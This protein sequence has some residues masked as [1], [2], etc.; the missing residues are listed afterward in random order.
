MKIKSQSSR[1]ETSLRS[2]GS[3]LGRAR[4]SQA[5]LLTALLLMGSGT[6]RAQRSQPAAGPILNHLNGV[7]TWYRHLENADEAAGR[8]SDALY[9]EDARALARRAVE[10]AF[11]S[12]ESEVALLPAQEAKGPSGSSA[13]VS[14]QQQSLAKSAASTADRIRLLQ[15][16]IEALNTRIP[17]ARGKRRKDLVSQRDELGSE[18]DLEKTLQNAIQKISAFLSNGPTAQ[19]GIVKQIADLKRTIPD[20][21]ANPQGRSQAAK[22]AISP[23][24][25]ASG[26]GL[27]GRAS[28]LFSQLRAMETV[29]ALVDEATAVRKSANDIRAPLLAMLRSILL[30]G[31]QLANQP[32]TT[33][34]AQ[35]E[36]ARESLNSLTA[37]FKQLSNA[38]V[39]LSQEMIVLDQSR[40]NLTQW[41]SSISAEDS[42]ILRSVLARVFAILIGLGLVIVFSEVWRR[43]TIRYVRETRR[44]RQLLLVRRFVTAFLMVVVIALGFVTE[45]SSLATFAG[46]LT[47]GIAVALQTVILSI[48]AYFFLIGRYGVRVGDRITVSGVTGEVVDIGL[49]RFHMMELAG[50]EIDLYP[51]GRMVAFSNSVLF[52]N[53]PLFRQLPGTAYAWHEVAVSFQR[54]GNYKDA[55][56]K[57]LEGVNSVYSEYREKLERQYNSIERLTDTSI[58]PPAPGTQVRFMENGFELV[59][60]YP[61]DVHHSSEIDTQVTKRLTEIINGVP[62][63]KAAAGPVQVRPALKA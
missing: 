48:A 37:R 22:P 9:L 38:S 13:E 63:F 62:E 54:D 42:Q 16:Q 44:R 61:V 6:A 18:L 52:Q 10:L 11:Q 45:F 40:A 19:N 28:L 30:E 4:L 34:P 14:S 57:L 35:M 59:V 5:T 47:A 50:T 43:A 24:Q 23:S 2:V 56:S 12:A 60:R 3:G 32:N 33:D 7:I 46:F 27:I 53:T 21:S 8:P 15:S 20:L 29:E 17:R 26:S 25:R 55:Q 49:V 58:P 1:H 41:R 51:T 36:R 39:P 31:R